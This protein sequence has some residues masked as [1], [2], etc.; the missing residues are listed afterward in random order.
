M[1]SYD[2]TFGMRK[3]LQLST[4][5]PNVNGKLFRNLSKDVEDETDKQL[6]LHNAYRS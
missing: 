6:H 5:G 2:D 3:L 4:D 1:R